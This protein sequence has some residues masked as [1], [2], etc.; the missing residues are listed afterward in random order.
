MSRK[1]NCKFGCAG[2]QSG[3]YFRKTKEVMSSGPRDGG[4]SLKNIMSQNL[5]AIPLIAH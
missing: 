2:K 3:Y 4:R 5:V 1:R